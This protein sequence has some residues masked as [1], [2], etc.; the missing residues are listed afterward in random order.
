MC[1]RIKR[2]ILKGQLCMQGVGLLLGILGRSV[3]PGSLNPD[4]ISDHNMVPLNTLEN[5]TCF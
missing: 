5:H 3:Q 2:D 1:M 4:P